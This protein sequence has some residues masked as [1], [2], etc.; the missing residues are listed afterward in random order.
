VK[1]KFELGEVIAERRMTYLANDGNHHEVLVRVGKPLLDP[2]AEQEHWLCHYQISGLGNNVVKAIFGVDSMQAL[3]LGIHT[4][5]P[6]WRPIFE[7]RAESFR[8]TARMMPVLSS[9]VEWLSNTRTRC[10][11][12]KKDS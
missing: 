4:I 2:G 8:V 12:Y 7:T 6:N 10:F 3:L 1:R 5:Q 11:H 9:R